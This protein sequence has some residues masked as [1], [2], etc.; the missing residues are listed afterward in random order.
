MCNNNGLCPAA[1][2]YSVWQILSR[3]K[4]RQEIENIYIKMWTFIVTMFFNH[5]QDGQNSQQKIHS[6]NQFLRAKK[7]KLSRPCLPFNLFQ[8]SEKKMT[9]AMCCKGPTKREKQDRKKKDCG[10]FFESHSFFKSC[11]ALHDR[12]I[13]L[14]VVFYLNFQPR[15]CNQIY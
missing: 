12:F 11:G 3:M 8:L 5:L 13:F 9:L 7:G 10:L 14:A 2:E 4:K 15:L 1:P 6:S